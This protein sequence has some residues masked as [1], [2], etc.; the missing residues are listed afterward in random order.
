MTVT[1][2][3]EGSE[4]KDNIQLKAYLDE[5]RR[6]EAELYWEF[7]MAAEVIQVNLS[8]IPGI[9][10]KVRARIIA[11]AIHAIAELHK[12]AVG[13]FAKVWASF[14]K[15]FEEELE[16][17]PSRKRKPKSTFTFK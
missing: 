15:H 7:H 4:L 13:A 2:K 5:A 6:I 17:A 1:E 3:L 14:E 12:A 10:S 11:K 9:S 8:R 16:G